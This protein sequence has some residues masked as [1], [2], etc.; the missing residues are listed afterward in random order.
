MKQASKKV[1]I[2]GAVLAAL[3]SSQSFATANDFNDGFYFGGSV[4]KAITKTKPYGRDI[5]ILNDA[6]IIPSAGANFEIKYKNS[7]VYGALVGYKLDDMRYEFSYSQS[8][9]KFGK[10]NEYLANG[11]VQD[12]M[13]LILDAHTSYKNVGATAYKDFGCDLF[14]KPYL[15]FGLGVARFKSHVAPI[16]PHLNPAKTQTN[17]KPTAQLVAGARLPITDGFQLAADYKYFSSIGKVGAIGKRFANHSLN[18]SFLFQPSF[19]G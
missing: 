19:L 14:F 12:V 4:G 16:F 6:T 1:V 18:L 8:K 7:D 17:T 3:V 5:N 11:N 2:T 10:I 13:E 9:H 15:G